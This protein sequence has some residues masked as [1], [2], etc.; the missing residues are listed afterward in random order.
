M[1]FGFIIIRHVSSEI[2]NQYW[3]ECYQS[4]RKFYNEPILIVDDSSNRQFLVEDIPLQ[5]CTV[6]YDT[7]H[8]GSAELLPYYYFHKLKPFDVAVIL[9]DSCFLQAKLDFT[10]GTEENVRFFWTFSHEF[11]DEIFP[12]INSLLQNIPFY[13]QHIDHYWRKQDWIGSF[14]AMSVLRWS[15]LDRIHSDLDLFRT[16]LPHIYG[17]NRRSALERVLPLLMQQY[18]KQIVVYFGDIHTYIPW[19]STFQQYLDGEFSFLP[20]VRIWTGR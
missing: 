1:S 2:T 15:F 6:I 11:D 13:D 9:H 8:K 19:G 12:I 4:I 5:N 7:E 17:R 16:L 18:E 3:K 20:L 14:G 10:L